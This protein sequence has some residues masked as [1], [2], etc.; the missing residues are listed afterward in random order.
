MTYQ[1]DTPKPALLY[2]PWEIRFNAVY[3]KRG[4][5]KFEMHA[6]FFDVLIKYRI[7]I[8]LDQLRDWLGDGLHPD[9]YTSPDDNRGSSYVYDLHIA[10]DGD[11]VIPPGI[12]SKFWKDLVEKLVSK[13]EGGKVESGGISLADLKAVYPEL[14]TQAEKEQ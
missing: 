6:P 12:S 11:D 7:P 5:S 4:F 9:K 8:T 3:L 2:L 13:E 1:D 14:S 10:R